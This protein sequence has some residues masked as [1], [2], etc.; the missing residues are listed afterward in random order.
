MKR[1]QPSGAQNRKK[2]K[3]RAESD[4]QQRGALDA[5]VRPR[6]TS[7][8][9][10]TEA[11]EHAEEN[12]TQPEE[13][14]DHG[15]NGG[16]D[17]DQASSESFHED[18]D[19]VQDEASRPSTSDD[20]MMQQ[21]HH[22][23][24]FDADIQ[25]KKTSTCSDTCIQNKDFGF[26]QKPIS[27]ALRVEILKLGPECFQNKNAQFCETEGRSFSATWFSKTATN[28]SIERK[29]LLY[30]P[31][32]DACYCF[33]CFLFQ[34]EGNASSFSQEE[35]FCKWRKLNPRVPDHESSSAHR[36]SVRQY[37]TLSLSL[38]RHATIDDSVQRQL[39]QEARQWEAVISRVAEVISFLAKQNLA[40]RGHRGE[41]ISNIAQENPTANPG[42]FL[43]TIHLL[44]KFDSTLDQLLTTAKP[45]TVTYL[46]NY[47]QNEVIN[48]LG[49]SVRNV[50]ISEIKQAKYFSMMFD[51]T[52][53]LSHQDQVSEIIRYV[54]IDYDSNTVQIR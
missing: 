4:A 7:S 10:I 33:P 42:N 11:A 21:H 44:A 27:D 24:D 40:L 32:K 31:S 6:V 37:L 15:S 17:R 45:K 35:G 46:S 34:G 16:D 8:K 3:A 25:S 36:E 9:P 13:L 41:N 49:E 47:T 39:D 22:D 30:S 12:E 48:L 14:E 2:K 26:L 29:W 38:K 52:P 23:S 5:W 51:S 50:I 54:H 1:V 20:C 28:E 18:E 43:A 53:D 19:L